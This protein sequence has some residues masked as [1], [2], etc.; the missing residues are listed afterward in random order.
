[1]YENVIV[2]FDGSLGGRLAFAP[3]SDLAWRCNARLVVV[4]NTELEN[5]A[6]QGMLKDKAKSLSGPDVD[7][8]V[9]ADHDLGN[10]LVAAAGFRSH[11]II[12]LPI[13]PKPSG[14][15]RKFALPVIADQV[16]RAMPCPVMTVGPKADVSRGLAMTELVVGLD[17]SAACEQALPVAADW[18]RALKVAITLIGVVAEGTPTP[19]TAEI[20]Y[21]EAHATAL[22]AVVPTVGVELREAKT[23]AEGLVSYLDAND[24]SVI[25]LTTVGRNDPPAKGPLGSTVTEVLATSQRPL[26]LIKPR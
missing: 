19:H 25:M 16:L 13:Q 10:A 23:P 8:W 12:C 1:V 18:A 22:R 21:L 9:D 20:D 11:P 24:N 6:L 26:V 17:G 15:R 3:A 4:N 7:F 5:T 2:P 14:L